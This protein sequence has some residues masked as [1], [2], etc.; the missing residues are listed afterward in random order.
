MKTDQFV[1]LESVGSIMELKTGNI[2][3]AQTNGKPDLN[4]PTHLTEVSEEW[5]ESL[6]SVDEAFVGIWFKNYNWSK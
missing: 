4:S 6:K 3:P 5:L 2:F 1:N